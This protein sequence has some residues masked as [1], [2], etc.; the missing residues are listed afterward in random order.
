NGNGREQCL[1]TGGKL[2]VARGRIGKLMKLVRKAFKI[3]DGSRFSHG[4]HCRSVDVPMRGDGQHGFG[5]WHFIAQTCPSVRVRVLRNRVHW[6]SVAEEGNRHWRHASRT[7]LQHRT[8]T[9]Q[10]L[11]CVSA[12]AKLGSWRSLSPKPSGPSS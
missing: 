7:S 2:R 5:P 8:A 9:R 11:C 6:V 10:P 4:S 12:V 3:V 1:N